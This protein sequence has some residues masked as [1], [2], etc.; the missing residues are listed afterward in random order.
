MVEALA[1]SSVNL[2]LRTWVKSEDYWAL[3]FDITENVKK[4]FDAAGIS[5]P[6][7]QQDVHLY[8][9]IDL[10]PGEVIR[11]RQGEF[12]CSHEYGDLGLLSSYP[13]M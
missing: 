13:S 12:F 2:K 9:Q 4:Q 7:P 6:F 5:I 1:D 8:N 11:S 10:D 3:F